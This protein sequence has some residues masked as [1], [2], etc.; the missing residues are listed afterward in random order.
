MLTSLHKKGRRFATALFTTRFGSI[1]VFF[2][3]GLESVKYNFQELVWASSTIVDLPKGITKLYLAGDLW[4]WILLLHVSTMKSPKGERALGNVWSW[5][6]V[7]SVVVLCFLCATCFV[8][9]GWFWKAFLR[10]VSGYWA[11]TVLFV[12]CL[13]NQILP[14]ATY[15]E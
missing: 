5:V 7:L 10:C 6:V 3:W 4:R 8:L 14:D 1:L 11:V 2:F 15:S 9:W 12:W 13:K